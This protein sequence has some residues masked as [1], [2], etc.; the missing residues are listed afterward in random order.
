[1]SSP[2]SVQ[3]LMQTQDMCLSVG[4]GRIDSK[5]DDATCAVEGSRSVFMIHRNLKLVLKMLVQIRISLQ[6]YK[7]DQTPCISPRRVYTHPAY[8]SLTASSFIGLFTMAA[9]K[10]MRT[11]PSPCRERREPSWVPKEQAF[12]RPYES[13]EG[14]LGCSSVYSVMPVVNR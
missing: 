13:I 11:A 9:T 4:M 5:I 10:V 7:R 14:W 1:M 2:S 6:I 3:R 8:L 12:R